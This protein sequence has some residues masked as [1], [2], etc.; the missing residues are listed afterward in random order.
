MDRTTKDIHVLWIYDQPIN[1]SNGG[2]ERA[3]SSVM[4][5][6]EK[7]GYDC[8]GCLVIPI[9]MEEDITHEGIV[10]NDIYSFMKKN[11]ISIVINQL[12]FDKRLLER[13]FKSGGRRWREE[14]G[15]IISCMHFAPDMVTFSLYDAIRSW[16]SLSMIRKF[17]RM[18]YLLFSPM[19]YLRSRLNLRGGIKFCYD[20]SDGFV[21]L[22]R[23]YIERIKQIIGE[24]C[25]NKLHV[26]NNPLSYSRFLSLNELIKKE[27]LV[28]CVARLTEKQKRVSLVLKTW[29]IVQK[30]S[31]SKNWKLR[32][33]GDGPDRSVYE[34][35]VKENEIENVEFLGKIEPE[36]EYIKAALCVTTSPS[37]GWGLTLTEAMQ[38]GCVPIAMNSSASFSDIISDGCDGL[39]VRDGDCQVM[40]EAILTLMNDTT[41]RNM[42]A[43]AGLKSCSRFAIDNIADK[44]HRL[45]SNV[46]P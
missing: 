28:L 37:E 39:L 13:F 25:N 2:T 14:G 16:H 35:I 38:K 30:Y 21:V 15:K 12:A 46:L 34:K 17:K 32:I 22:S 6:L 45:I 27:K 1:A 5:G 33:V 41:K 23:N 19:Y 42:M 40:A 44:W 20:E 26:I 36:E 31:S 9:S 7:I 3:T 43:K 18:I 8:R 11:A 29:K 10:V 4:Q 24:Q